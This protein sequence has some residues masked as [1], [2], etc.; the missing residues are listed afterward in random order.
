MHNLFLF[1]V[2]G[3]FVWLT[4]PA[5]GQYIF[6]EAPKGTIT[7]PFAITNDYIYVQS[8]SDLSHSGLASY[9]FDITEPGP[10]VIQA[11][12]NA[13]AEGQNAVLVNIDGEPEDRR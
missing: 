3:I 13:P 6:I 1:R 8:N 5:F 4:A 7:A 10:Y 12:V 11:L 2:I 9:S